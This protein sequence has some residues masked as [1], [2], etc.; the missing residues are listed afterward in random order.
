MR[1]LGMQGTKK[2]QDIFSDSKVPPTLRHKLPI[3][4]CQGEII[5]IPGFRIAQG[6]EVGPDEAKA[7][8]LAIKP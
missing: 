6:W 2:L 7:L 5:W 3:I 1:P 4:E 8:Q